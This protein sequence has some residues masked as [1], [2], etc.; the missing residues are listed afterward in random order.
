MNGEM[1]WKRVKTLGYTQKQLAEKLG[2]TRQAVSTRFKASVV[3]TDFISEL[4]NMLNQPVEYFFTGNMNDIVEKNLKVE[5]ASKAL[6][7]QPVTQEIPN[8]ILILQLE[9]AKTRI[10]DLEQ[11][12]KAKDELISLL[13]SQNK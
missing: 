8:N 12:I 1:L 13:I 6:D 11:I 7:G 10:L 5:E 3:S 2:I 9:A 4:S